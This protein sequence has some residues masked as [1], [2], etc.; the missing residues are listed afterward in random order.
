MNVSAI[1]GIATLQTERKRLSRMLGLGAG[2]TANSTPRSVRRRT[3]SGWTAG[4]MSA[5]LCS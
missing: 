2:A 1:S 4:K 5:R 3:S